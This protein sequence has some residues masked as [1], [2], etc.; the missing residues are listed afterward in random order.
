MLLASRCSPSYRKAKARITNLT[1]D[2]VT[3]NTCKTKRLQD[4]CIRK[5]TFCLPLIT[6]TNSNDTSCD[7][8]C[9]VF[10]II[11][12]NK[13]TSLQRIIANIINKDDNVWENV[14]CLERSRTQT[15]TMIQFKTRVSI[16]ISNNPTGLFCFSQQFFFI[17]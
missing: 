8:C 10:D 5:R 14:R 16:S 11:S 17:R 2:A 15:L 9:D 3:P 13:Q 7:S 1:R 4:K 12:I 6:N